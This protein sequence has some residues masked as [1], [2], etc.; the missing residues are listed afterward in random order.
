MRSAADIDAD[1]DLQA[2]C[3]LNDEAAWREL[4]ERFQAALLHH[5]RRR[6]RQRGQASEALAEDLV[7]NVCDALADPDSGQLLG[8]DA[9]RGRGSTTLG[10][11]PTAS[12]RPTCAVSPGGGSGRRRRPGPRRSR[13]P[14]RWTTWTGRSASCSRSYR[15][16]YGSRCCVKSDRWRRA[17]RRGPLPPSGKRSI[18][19]RYGY[20]ST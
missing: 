13:R 5:V 3:L 16:S 4:R 10:Q 7:Q 19:S 20:K 11:W 17:S 12:C 2:R 1:R 6:L 8:Y 14:A 18:G 9:A 15:R